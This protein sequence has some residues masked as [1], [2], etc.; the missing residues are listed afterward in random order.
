[1]YVS[2]H[3]DGHTCFGKTKADTCFFF[4][5]SCH[6]C[7]E[8]K[9]GILCLIARDYREGIDIEYRDIGN[10]ENYKMFLGIKEKL[11]LKGDIKVPAVF[12]SGRLLIGRDIIEKTLLDLIKSQEGIKSFYN[13]VRIQAVEIEDYFKGF[14]PA[15]IIAAGLVDGINPCA[16]TVIIFLFRFFPCR[17]TSAVNSPVSA[18]H[19]WPRFFD[20]FFTRHRAV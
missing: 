1:V 13:T 19:S 8:V 10:V 2:S 14:T 17:G 12:F 9:D 5:R 6:N 11:G 18:Q 4:S 20:I 15:A 16:F 7:H 3:W